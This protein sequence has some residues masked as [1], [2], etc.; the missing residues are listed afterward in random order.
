MSICEP[1]LLHSL[2]VGADPLIANTVVIFLDIVNR[3]RETE[4]LWGELADRR[5]QRIGGDYPVA[6]RL[7][8]GYLRIE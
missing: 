5:Q 6:L 4:I 1:R 8:K 7:D 2:D 3:D